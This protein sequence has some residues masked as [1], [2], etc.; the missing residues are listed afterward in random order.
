[1]KL[2]LK[3]YPNPKQ[4]QFFSATS[5]HI[6]YGGARGGGKSWAMRRK[7]VLLALNYPGL[8][9][10]LLRRTLPE[11]RE[12]HVLPLLGEL[13][14]IATYKDTDKAFVFPNGSRIKLGYCDNEADVY[15]YQGQ[16]YDVIGLEE[17]THFTDTMRDFFITCNRSTRTDFKPRM[18]YTANPGNV[19]HAW[20]KRLF[21]DREYRGKERTDDYVFIPAQVYDNKALVD[22]NPEYIEALE[23]LPNDMRKAHLYGDWSAFAGQYFTEFRRDL[24]VITPFVIP[25][26]WRRYRALDYGLDMLACYWFAVDE[27]NNVYVYK[28]LHEPNLIITDAANRIIAINGMDKIECTYAPPDL[29]NRRQD[30]GKSAAEI[31]TSAGVG[32]V[33]AKNDRINGWYS[34]KEWLKAVIVKDEQT[35]EER[36]TSRIKIFDTC[37]NLIKC[38][39][40]LQ[41]DMKNVN[42][43]AKEP[44]DITHGPDA[45][46][47]FLG[48]RHSPTPKKEMYD[49]FFASRIKKQ[50]IS[51]EVTQG[52]L[53][54]GMGVR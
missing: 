40:Q 3:G 1:M 37:K 7:F 33:K 19:G 32:F 8:K 10:L 35:G 52:Y 30:T 15:Q 27:Y 51:G 46:R 23:S 45:L 4:E 39:P 49:D 50:S 29:W 21:V 20:F 48:M 38:L 31:F 36:T 11:L 47:Y 14:G 22:N 9:L 17:A 44:H 18:Y 28:E 24:H 12:N 42:D 2:Q 54:Y 5:R 16:E 13:Y 26:E 6:A 43:V 25:D 53:D 41:H 34:V